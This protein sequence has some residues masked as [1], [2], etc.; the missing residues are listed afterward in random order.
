MACVR[1]YIECT[2]SWLN[3]VVCM[4]ATTGVRGFRGR[5]LYSTGGRTLKL[6]SSYNSTAAAG[7]LMEAALISS[8]QRVY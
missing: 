2:A 3:S 1:Q 8:F 6:K 5:R 4:C 7:I